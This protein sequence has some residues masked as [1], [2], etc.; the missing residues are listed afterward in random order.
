MVVGSRPIGSID[1]I[2]SVDA[3]RGL[4]L[5]GIALVH[6]QEHYDCTAGGPTITSLMQSG[7]HGALAGKMFALLAICFG[8][9]CHRVASGQLNGARSAATVVSGRRMIVLAAIGYA[10]SLLYRDD[11]LTTLAIVGLL[12]LPMLAIGPRRL[13]LA[14]ALLC[15]AQPFMLVGL[16]HGVAP[17]QANAQNMGTDIAGHVYATGSLADVIRVN[18]WT[19]EA[20]KWAY[21]L[22]SGRALQTIGYALIGVILGRTGFFEDGA[23]APWP[24]RRL[25]L[26]AGAAMA[27]LI[28]SK[29]YFP[30]GWIGTETE[31]ARQKLLVESWTDLLTSFAYLLLF[32]TL[33]SGPMRKLLQP[34]CA[35]GRLSLTFYIGQ[36]LLLVPLFYHFGVGLCDAIGVKEAV[37]LGLGAG[38]AQVPLAIWWRRYFLLGPMEWLWRAGAQARL[39]IPFRRRNRPAIFEASLQSSVAGRS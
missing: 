9:S 30:R 38:L 27:A 23:F 31:A 15:F 4:A 13:L 34:F 11:I 32:R 14:A 2:G 25:L 20:N 29:L 36:S 6:V 3:L 35:L 21:L 18:A 5:V 10:H 8:F 1:R 19:G 26:L 17:V 28:A 33:W 22:A 16:V 39:D 12:L 37:L 7:I 24:M